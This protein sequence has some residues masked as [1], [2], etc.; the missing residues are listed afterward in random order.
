MHFW[1]AYKTACEFEDYTTAIPTVSA[2]M[3]RASRLNLKGRWL[4]GNDISRKSI[5]RPHRCISTDGLFRYVTTD[6]IQSPLRV[7]QNMEICEN[8]TLLPALPKSLGHGE[9]KGILT[10]TGVRVESMSW[11]D[12]GIDCRLYSPRE[13]RIEV[14][15][16]CEQRELTLGADTYSEVHFDI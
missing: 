11:S 12:K 2:C 10:R 3:C 4:S 15:A 1:G 5:R 8:I 16:P 7:L 13:C 6:K 9:L 14:R